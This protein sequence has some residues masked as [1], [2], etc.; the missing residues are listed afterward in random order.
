MGG[1]K[2]ASIPCGPHMVMGALKTLGLVTQ[3]VGG[4]GHGRMMGDPF[5]VWIS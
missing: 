4:E 5:A 2:L 3:G 1:F